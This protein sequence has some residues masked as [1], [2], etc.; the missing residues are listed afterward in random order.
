MMAAKAAHLLPLVLSL[1]GVSA[2]EVNPRGSYAINATAGYWGAEADKVERWQSYMGDPDATGAFTLPGFNI[3]QPWSGAEP[4]D[5]TVQIAVKAGM[6]L[7]RFD[8]DDDDAQV[9]TGGMVWIEPPDGLVSGDSYTA[10]GEWSPLA[11]VY[12]STALKSPSPDE[13]LTPFFHRDA[14]DD[15]PADG[16]CAGILSDECIEAIES[17]AG[18]NHVRPNGTIPWILDDAKCPGIGGSSRLRFDTPFRLTERGQGDAAMKHNEGWLVSFSSAEHDRGNETDY[19]THGSQYV[20]ILFQWLRT[21]DGSLST[22]TEKPDGEISTLL[23]VAVNE[24]A[25][26]KELP[27]PDKDYLEAVE[28]AEA[29][30]SFFVH[31]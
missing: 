17:A 12:E 1:R 31:P 7:P 3:S 22:D 11:V 23:C 6:V 26:G 29:G 24:A 25:D 8:E 18:E 20:P 14:G 9:V 15:S 30:K 19:A 2:A 27:V 4:L 16:S 5:W 21:D 13:P 28:D 10:S